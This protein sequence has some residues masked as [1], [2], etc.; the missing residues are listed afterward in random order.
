EAVTANKISNRT[1]T[2]GKLALGAVGIA[3][4]NEWLQIPDTSRPTL[5]RYFSGNVV[6]IR[7]NGFNDWKVHDSTTIPKRD[8]DNGYLIELCRVQ[9]E[10]LS[11]GHIRVLI[12]G[13]PVV[14]WNYAGEDWAIFTVTIDFRLYSDGDH[15]FEWQ[16]S[17]GGWNT[18]SRNRAI[19]QNEQLP[20]RY[21]RPQYSITEGQTGGC[22]SNCQ[23]TCQ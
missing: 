9:L 15:T 17:A 2:S 14:V 16:L 21:G 7:S 8:D 18:Q 6:S 5:R 23:L 20:I 22:Y 12:D 19:F 1:I 4:L 11:V 3:Q 10:V 13:E